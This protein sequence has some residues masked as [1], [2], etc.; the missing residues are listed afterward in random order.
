[1]PLFRFTP[2]TPFPS[3]P[4]LISQQWIFFFFSISTSYLSLIVQQDWQLAK[5]H[6]FMTKTRYCW[7]RAKVLQATDSKQLS[8][9]CVLGKHNLKYTCSAKIQITLTSDQ[10]EDSRSILFLLFSSNI[11]I[12]TT[13]AIEGNWEHDNDYPVAA[14]V[15]GAQIQ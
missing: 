4:H 1:M 7:A 11:L 6:M 2:P 9:C 10:R 3:F 15:T 5:M 8:L 12:C 14:S 13:N